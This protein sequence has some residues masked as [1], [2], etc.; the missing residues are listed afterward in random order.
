[1]MA[2]NSGTCINKGSV[3]KERDAEYQFSQL[4][5][6]SCLMSLLD[7]FVR[8]SYRFIHIFSS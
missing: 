8:I 7:R 5:I 1:M 3:V 2:C 4:F 6:L